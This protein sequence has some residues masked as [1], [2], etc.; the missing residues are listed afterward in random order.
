MSD[1]SRTAAP[2]FQAKLSAQIAELRDQLRQSRGVLELD[3]PKL[4]SYELELNEKMATFR[5]WDGLY[6][7]DVLIGKLLADPLQF[8]DEGSNK[9]LAAAPDKDIGEGS[10]V[11]GSSRTTAPDGRSKTV[12]RAELAVRVE[13]L[14]LAHEAWRHLLS[15]A[16]AKCVEREVF[17]AKAR[18]LRF[19]AFANGKLVAEF[20]Q[21]IS[22]QERMKG[23]IAATIEAQTTLSEHFEAFLDR[24]GTL[25]GTPELNSPPLVRAEHSVPPAAACF[26]LDLL[27]TKADRNVIPGDLTEEFRARIPNYG[28]RGA[29]LWFWA[30]LMRT[31][32]WRNPVCRSALVGSL[33]RAIGWILRQIGN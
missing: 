15:E 10:S 6:P 3:V 28:Y 32:M 7:S 29:R 19:P 22:E 20:R 4:K 27:L 21:E 23:E 13:A 25:A 5:R 26:L 1:S 9:D 14:R 17:L 12:L 2:E 33:M 8:G 16:K 18:N 30:E 31:I 24:V 11:S